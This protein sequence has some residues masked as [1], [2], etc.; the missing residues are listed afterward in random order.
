MSYTPAGTGGDRRA[1]P[2]AG[3]S[4]G[5]P[6]RATGRGRLGARE[7]TRLRDNR[8]QRPAVLLQERLS[9][10]GDIEELGLVLRTRVDYA[11]ERAVGQDPKRGHPALLCLSRTPGPK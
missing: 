1:G 10:P 7:S 8:E 4:R 2:G 9:D 6:R 11:D 5:P 3:V